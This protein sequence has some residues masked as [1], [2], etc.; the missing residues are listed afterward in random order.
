MR[1]GIPLALAAVLVSW[2]GAARC[3]ETP[4]LP[5]AV[6][7]ASFEH[8]DKAPAGWVL[9]GSGYWAREAHLGRRCAAVT[10]DGEQVSYWRTE[11]PLRP[12][13][14]YVVSFWMKGEGEGGCVTSGPSFANH[15][16][17]PEEEWTYCESIFATPSSLG[18]AYLRFGQWRLKGKVLFDDIEVRPVTPVHLRE[19][20]LE[21]GGGEVIAGGRYECRPMEATDGNYSRNLEH[22]SC[23]WNTNRWRM[24]QGSV[25]TYRHA[26]GAGQGA[27]SVTVTV[28]YHQAGRCLVTASKDG[29]HYLPVGELDRAGERTWRLPAAL[30]PA[31]AVWVRLAAAGAGTREDDSAP[32][33]FQV[34]DYRYQAELAAKVADVS[35]QTTCLQ[36]T[37]SSPQVAVTVDSLGRLEPCPDNRLRLLVASP[38]ARRLKVALQVG[39]ARA[40]QEFALAAG[41]SALTL[42]YALEGAGDFPLAL[43]VSEGGRPLYAAQARVTVPILLAADYGELL[44]AGPVPLWWCGATYKVSTTRPVPRQQGQAVQLAAARNEYEPFQL[45]LRPSRPLPRVEVSASPLVGPGGAKIAAPEI[46]LVEY[47][48][49]VHP[50][51]GVSSAGLWPD[52]LPRYDGPF[53]VAAGRNQPLWL[54]VYVPPRAPAGAYQGTVTINAGGQR[55]QAPVK[56]WV[57]DFAL[58]EHVSIRSGFGFSPGLVAQYDNLAGE[59]YREVIDEYYRAFQSH[60]MAPYTPMR[61]PEVSFGQRQLEERQGRVSFDWTDFD[62]DAEYYLEELGFNSFSMPITGLGGG[63]PGSKEAAELAGAKAG[64]PE[65]RELMAQYL[66]GIQ[67][68]LEEKGWLE[69]AYVYWYDEPA[70][71][72]YEYVRGGMRTLQEY[73][74]KLNR[75]LTVRPVKEL[76]GEVNTWCVPVGAYREKD[77]QARQRL[78]EEIWWYLCCGPRAPYVGLFIDHPAV[79]FR[80]W[81]WMSYKYQVTGILIWTVNWWTSAT[82]FPDSLQNPWED[83]MSYVAGYDTPAGTKAFWGNGDGRLWYPAN[84][85]VGGDK[86]PHSEG[87][88]PSLRVEL[89]REGI[90]DYEYFK[91]LEGLAARPGAPA[92][93]KALLAVP[94]EVCQDLT[95]YSFD[96]GPM[97]RHREKMA[98]MIELLTRK[99]G[100]R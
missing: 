61:R 76:Y 88:V 38:R 11:V 37:D 64:T 4:G 30:F 72:V 70:P 27:A 34:T 35:G 12:N 74:P 69:K 98:R 3:V 10:G 5:A 24:A 75:F 39:P 33:S 63:I 86:R 84:R 43:Q 41:K 49:V 21:L 85:R 40:E 55:L 23:D 28:D 47:V 26:V 99:Q 81:L 2:L 62:R 46:R 71:E 53:S 44:S 1:A 83:P 77:C 87:P 89:L 9:E 67:R 48:K 65:Y 66:G 52:P 95:H 82:A 36:V 16:L 31:R 51:D 15:D 13:C 58:P 60:R 50:T 56:L 22:F 7:N 8:G 20:Q 6:A 29:Q 92:A 80:V 32:G 42:P 79:D 68:H 45:V 18:E 96:P 73:A 19:G 90:E 54:V 57:W 97:M 91:L 94:P 25:V 78:G 17:G 100:E 59:A 14:V 93:A